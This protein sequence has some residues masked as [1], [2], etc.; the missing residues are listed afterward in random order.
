MNQGRTETL[1]TRECDKDLQ[2]KVSGF[3]DAYIPERLILC[4][5]SCPF[6]MKFIDPG[7]NE[8]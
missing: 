1:I 5:S 3:M 7:W 2:Q 4:F 6:T 8:R